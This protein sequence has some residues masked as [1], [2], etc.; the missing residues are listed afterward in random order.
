MTV[1][2]MRAPEHVIARDRKA[3]FME[4]PT[5]DWR[6][7]FDTRDPGVVY[8]AELDK[9]WEQSAE[10]L[11]EVLVHSALNEATYNARSWRACS[12]VEEDRLAEIVAPMSEVAFGGWRWP[13]PGCRIFM[14]EL[15]VAEIG[16]AMG[17]HVPWEHR[18]GF[19]A[20]R[21]AANNPACLGY[22]D[23]MSA[24]NWVTPPFVRSSDVRW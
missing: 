11:S 8:D 4:D 7:A 9:E 3:V 14:N 2:R 6:W 15:M 18:P 21:V 23:N 16:P 5:G 20:V 1:K 12:A 17:L 22:L 24:I 10:G 13:A 19:A